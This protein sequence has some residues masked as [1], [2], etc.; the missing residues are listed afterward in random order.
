MAYNIEKAY[1]DVTEKFKL[2]SKVTKVVSD[3][4]S[5]M[6]KAFQV[7]LPPFILHKSDDEVDSYNEEQLFPDS[8]SKHDFV[9]GDTDLIFSFLTYLKESAVLLTLNNFALKIAS[10]IQS[11]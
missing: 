6:A 8:V 2:T 11:L 9:E 4:A 5:S 3:N 7:S 1:D 10:R